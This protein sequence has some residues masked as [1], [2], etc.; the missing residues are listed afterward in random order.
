MYWDPLRRQYLM[1][2]VSPEALLISFITLMWNN[3][4]KNCVTGY[5]T[6]DSTYLAMNYLKQVLMFYHLKT[7]R[8]VNT[9]HI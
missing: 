5:L 1:T 2:H 3:K 8:Y 9:V 4:S 7:R 6:I